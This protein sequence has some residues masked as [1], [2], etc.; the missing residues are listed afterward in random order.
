VHI[1][2]NSTPIPSRKAGSGRVARFARLACEEQRARALVEA[3]A[4]A[5]EIASVA[6]FE[7]EPGKWAVEIQIADGFDPATVRGHVEAAAGEEHARA[8]EWREI[9]DR[10][11]IE[12]SLKGL[13]PVEAGRFLIHGAHDRARA[14]R[15][16]VPIEI[17]AA[18]A[19]GTGHHGTTRGCLLAFDRLLRSRSPTRILDVGTGTGVLAIAAALVLHRHVVATDIDKVAVKVARDNAR[20]NHVAEW[21]DCIHARGVAADAI[22]RR[23][24]YDLIFANILLPPLKLLATPLARLMAPGARIILSGLLTEHVN[25]AT[26]AYR[27]QGLMLEH[28]HILEGWATL[29]FRRGA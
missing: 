24:P 23:G 7:S 29:V 27:A 12:A 25:A 16:S 3:L 14:E 11:W 4:D 6:A 5:V 9:A 8:L 21:I 1:P 26:A 2:V 13:K 17:E 19:F 22:R 18:L 10:D 20:L 15:A 28:K